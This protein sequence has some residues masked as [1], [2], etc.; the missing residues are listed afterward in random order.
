MTTDNDV[1]YP[2]QIQDDLNQQSGDTSRIEAWLAQQHDYI[3]GC[4]NVLREIQ[5]LLRDALKGDVSR[6]KALEQAH[7][8]ITM[9]YPDFDEVT[10]PSEDE[11]QESLDKAVEQGIL[12][13]VGDR[14]RLTPK[15]IAD[16]EQQ[17]KDNPEAR[18]FM[19]KLRSHLA[20]DI[21]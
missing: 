12:E 7:D 11:L 14:Y 3:V 8:I 15:G 5:L 13:K 16:V 18:D 1:K 9:S 17:M 4:R 2:Q 6:R 19:R 10:A 20:D 21:D